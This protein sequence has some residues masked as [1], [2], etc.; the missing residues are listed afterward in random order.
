MFLRYRFLKYALNSFV[1]N[2][3]ILI[4][5]RCKSPS[6]SVF[7]DHAGIHELEKIVRSSYPLRFAQNWLKM[8][9]N[10]FNITIGVSRRGLGIQT[11][12]LFGNIEFEG[13]SPLMMAKKSLPRASIRASSFVL[14]ICARL[15]KMLVN[16]L[17]NLIKNILMY[18]MQIY[19]I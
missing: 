14:S 12:R 1:L 18:I 11:G 17:I 9:T 10:S 19:I 5:Y 8:F 13:A 15:Q 2:P 16:I 7:C 6:H 3:I 4:T